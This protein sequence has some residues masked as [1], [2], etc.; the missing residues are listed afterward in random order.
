MTSST[1]TTFR[2]TTLGRA[3]DIHA[4]TDARD[5]AVDEAVGRPQRPRGR[6]TL[7]GMLI[8]LVVLGTAAAWVGTHRSHRAMP[9]TEAMPAA[10][11]WC[12]YNFPPPHGTAAAD[13][14]LNTYACRLGFLD[15]AANPDVDSTPEERRVVVA[16]SSVGATNPQGMWDIAFLA[17]WSAGHDAARS[18]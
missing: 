5:A 6:R 8:G 14:N 18:A 12:A 7:T 11:A 17:G 3:A 10:T 2:S 9:A 15:G 13:P 16:A 4:T 1:T